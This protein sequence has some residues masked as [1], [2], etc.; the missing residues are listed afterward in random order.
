MQVRRRRRKRARE[1]IWIG[2]HNQ[3]QKRMYTKNKRKTCN[4]SQGSLELRETFEIT[5]YQSS[6]HLV[7]RM[8]QTLFA[9]SVENRT[10]NSRSKETDIQY[11][12]CMCDFGFKLIK[13]V[14][15]NPR[16]PI[17]IHKVG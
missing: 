13:Y 16:S 7:L 14:I 3:E 17:G 10:I 1:Y 9:Y 5:N 6:S 11:I 4:T 2:P 15:Y 8:K 12:M